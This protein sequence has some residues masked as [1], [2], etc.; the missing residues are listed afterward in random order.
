MAVTMIDDLPELSELERS[1]QMGPESG[2]IL[3]PGQEGVYK[4]IRQSHTA[5][6]EAGMQRLRPPQHSHS[7]PHS[8]S[9]KEERDALYDISCLEISNHIY[10]CP[11]CS[12]FYSNDKSPYI[13]CIVVLAIICLLLLKRVLDV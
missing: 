12:K 8:H 2:G 3:P 11:I 13:I 1:Q 4:A 7:H 9:H 10:E 6:L 5:P